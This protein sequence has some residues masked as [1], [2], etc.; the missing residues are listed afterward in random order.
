M[1]TLFAT[2]LA[3]LSLTL[4]APAGAYFTDPGG[5]GN[6]YSYYDT[7]VPCGGGRTWVHKHLAT[8]VIVQT[9]CVYPWEVPF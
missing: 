6:G 3:A 9:R 4:A 1:K 8:G 2:L 7:G 5:S